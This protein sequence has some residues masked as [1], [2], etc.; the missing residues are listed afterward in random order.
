M[1]QTDRVERILTDLEGINEDLLDLY[2]D[3][4][5]NGDPR[6]PAARNEHLRL[7]TDYNA[8]LE[9]FETAAADL[10]ALIEHITHVDMKPEPASDDTEHAS[11]L[12]EFAG[13]KPH[14]PSENYTWK[15]VY[16]FTL[17]GRAFRASK[18]NRFYA[19]FLQQL[20]ARDP[21]R[22]QQL[23]DSA[24]F[25]AGQHRTGFSRSPDGYPAP[26]SLP[27]GIYTNTSMSARNMLTN[28]RRL[29]DFFGIPEGEIVIY[30][31]EDRDA[32]K[33]AG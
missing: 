5:Q 14:P 6:D 3:I 21:E 10:R 4:Q 18:W 31:Q 29:L 1:I 17:S 28:V 15:R 9:A 24:P 2:S 11:I 25:N 26:L 19:T 32:Q 20:A 8:R 30:L 27:Y 12:R 22:F 23:P 7:L 33:G 13:M 16:G